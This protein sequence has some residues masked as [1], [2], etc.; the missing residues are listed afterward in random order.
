[1][2]SDLVLILT[3]SVFI[4]IGVV[5]WQKGSYLRRHGKKAGGIIFKN[6]FKGAGSRDN[7]LYFPVVRFLTDK[8][9]WITQET[10]VGHVTPC[11]EGEKVEVLYDPEN[12][13]YVEINSTL[14][15]KFI[16]VL[17]ASLGVIGLIAGALL[18][19]DIV[20]LPVK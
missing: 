20:E 18:Y 10:N 2:D 9:E 16:P 15:L 5:S 17:F 12:P 1:M 19:L 13:T 6:N 7:G 3:S 14:N 8:Q 4:V 11:D